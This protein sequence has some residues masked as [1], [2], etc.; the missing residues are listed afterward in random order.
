MTIDEAIA[1]VSDS[2]PIIKLL[3]QVKQGRMRPDDAG[4]RA[5]T[6]SWLETYRRVLTAMDGAA[7]LRRLDPSP[8]LK[9]LEE[10]G[11]IPAGHTTAASLREAFKAR[12]PSQ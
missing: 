3:L 7:E 6:D 1:T 12:L 11:V 8:R 4:L 10:S 9:V 2:D 5:I